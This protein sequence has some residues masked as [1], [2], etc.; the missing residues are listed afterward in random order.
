M[1]ANN[2]VYQFI[3]FKL[4]EAKLS[5][6]T[7]GQL[8]SFSI[9][10]NNNNYDKEQKICN[11]FTVVKLNFEGCD[12]SKFTFLSGY[13][14]NDEEWFANLETE[15][16][17]SIFLSVIFPFIR[18]KIRNICDDSRGSFVMPIIDLRGLKLENEIV[19]NIKKNN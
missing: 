13:K 7:D 2:P 5:R 14:I 12:E 6:N 18:E 15:N 10:V 16:K 19:F 17:N 3:G 8:T 9:Q 11:S 4:L 1:N